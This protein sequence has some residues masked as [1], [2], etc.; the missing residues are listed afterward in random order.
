ME[1]QKWPARKR[2]K[3]DLAIVGGGIAGLTAALNSQH[4]N[5]RLY[6]LSTELGGTS[7]ANGFQNIRFAQGAHYDLSYPESYGQ[8]ILSILEGL[9]I[10]RY[11]S[12]K[13]SWGFVDHQ[14][15]IPR[16]RKERCY[17]HGI[18]RNDVIPNTS[19]K[20]KFE[21]LMISFSGNVNLPTRL[22]DPKYHFLNDLT[23][24]GF[25]EKEIQLP[26]DMKRY[27]DYHMFDD[28]GGHSSQVSALA[29]V[30]YF[31]C[32]PYYQQAVDVFSP[33]EGNHYFIQKIAGKIHQE[34]VHTAHLVFSIEQSESINHLRILDVKRK[35]VI[36]IQA[37]EVIYAGQKHALKYICPGQDQIFSNVYAPWMVV[38]L[39][40]RQQPGQYGFWQNEYLGENP[41]FLGFVDSSVQNQESLKGYRVFTGYYCLKP[42][43][44]DYLTSV[45]EKKYAIAK[46][47]L[48]Y[49]EETLKEH[50]EVVACYIKVMGHAMAI[51][52]P[53][54][55]FQ[56]ANR[57]P[58]AK[59][60][61]AGVDNGRLPLLFEAMDSGLVASDIIRQ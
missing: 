27:I 14:H 1:S 9:E 22:I 26:D 50:I 20:K 15:V 58:K 33:P 17:D 59:I 41:D 46:E 54:H 28:Y 57:H 45:N 3:I 61:F 53:G 51:P 25:L 10:I 34:C 30:I 40:A 11:E 36:E 6:E 29:G 32:R 24:S 4:L 2:E 35:E 8:E 31:A 21:E 19:W 5:F 12:W 7:G 16:A 39:V 56:E 23:F 55:L 18:F 44:R 43:D 38:S 52:R 49:V 47:T 13:K 42:S 60:K 48:N 37:D